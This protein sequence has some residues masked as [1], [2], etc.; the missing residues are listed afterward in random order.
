MPVLVLA[1]L[2]RNP[3]S[4]PGKKPQ[5]SDLR[6]SGQIEQDADA[7]ILVH[8]DPESEAGEQGLPS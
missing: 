2:N 4:R 7:V 6:D 1:Q 8:H 5:A 3:A